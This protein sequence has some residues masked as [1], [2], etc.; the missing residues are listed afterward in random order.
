MLHLVPNDGFFPSAAA[1][2]SLIIISL[3]MIH[4]I[5]FALFCSLLFFSV[6]WMLLVVNVSRGCLIGGR[7]CG[8]FNRQ[9]QV[10]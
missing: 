2:C 9:A 4:S 5:P 6:S 3:L 10:E 8:R 1:H 7:R